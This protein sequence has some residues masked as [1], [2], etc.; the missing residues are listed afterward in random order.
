MNLRRME[1]ELAA[2]AY[3]AVLDD[4]EFD[5]F[6][7]RLTKARAD[8]RSMELPLDEERTL[9]DATKLHAA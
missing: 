2:H 1:H 9:R 6:L 8:L 3:A 5:G 7:A 4:A